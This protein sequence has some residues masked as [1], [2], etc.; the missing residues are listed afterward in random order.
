M[1]DAGEASVRLDKKTKIGEIGGKE[2]VKDIPGR[3]KVK[4]RWEWITVIKV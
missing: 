2:G 4:A 1:G 3:G